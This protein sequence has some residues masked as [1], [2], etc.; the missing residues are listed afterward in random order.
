MLQQATWWAIGR[1]LVVLG[2]V[3]AGALLALGWASLLRRRVSAQTQVIQ[4]Q[5]EEAAELV[6]AAGAASRSKSEFQANM[7]HEIRTP[8]NG[9]I[10]LTNLAL[11]TIGVSE[12]REYL[13]GVKSPPTPCSIS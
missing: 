11:G 13:E 4:K 5:L 8:M 3:L 7:S 6:R 12:E 9:I 1:A 2:V 10:G